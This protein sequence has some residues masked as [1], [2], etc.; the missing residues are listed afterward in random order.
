VV[1]LVSVGT[2]RNRRPAPLA[3]DTDHCLVDP[4]PIRFDAAVGLSV[5]SLHLVTS[6][7]TTPLD[8]DTLDVLFCIR[9]RQV[10]TIELNP[11]PTRRSGCPLSLHGFRADPLGRFEAA[12]GSGHGTFERRSSPS[13]L[14]TTL[15]STPSSEK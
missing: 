8:T 15:G 2:D 11:H 14:N 6:R 9:E 3:V 7:R 4:D 10:D 5:D 1:K 12:V 13:E